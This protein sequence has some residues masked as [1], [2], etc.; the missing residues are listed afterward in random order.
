MKD[1]GESGGPSE[2]VWRFRRFTTANILPCW[3]PP[4]RKSPLLTYRPKQTKNSRTGRKI[5]NDVLP[6]LSGAART[7]CLSRLLALSLDRSFRDFELRGETGP[8]R[9]DPRF[10]F[11]RAISVSEK[12]LLP[13]L[14]YVVQRVVA[15]DPRGCQGRINGWCLVE[16]LR[17]QRIYRRGGRISRGGASGRGAVAAYAARRGVSV[18]HGLTPMAKW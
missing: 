12:A 16:P 10:L 18:F 6:A 8:S 14:P 3:S 5:C 15:A 9:R 11:F 7:P 17:T 1:A 2:K 13:G 4:G